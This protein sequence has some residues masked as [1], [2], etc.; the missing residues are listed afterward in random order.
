MSNARHFFK[1]PA[2]QRAAFTLVEMLVVLAIIG[3][4][5]GILLPVIARSKVRAKAGLAKVDCAAIATAFTQ[6]HTDY[7]H[8]PVAKGQTANSGGDVTYNPPGGLGG[9]PSNSDAM[10]ILSALEELGGSKPNPG[11]SRN[12]SK[13]RYLDSKMTDSVEKPGMGPDGVFRDPFGNPFVITVDLDG[14][15]QCL[16]LLYGNPQVSGPD[17]ADIGQNGLIKKM[18]GPGPGYV[19]PKDVM[20]W[21]PG[22]DK[23]IG[24]CPAKQGENLDNILGWQ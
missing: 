5:V 2:G 6:Y 21:S 9:G 23:E 20:V 3:I 15:G 17:G 10:I 12:I 7:N 1:N 19:L 18:F 8:F 24:S 14:D 4:L 11:H 13:R 16:D 22:P